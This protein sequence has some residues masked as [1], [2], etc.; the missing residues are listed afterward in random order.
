MRGF[1]MLDHPT[2]APSSPDVPSVSAVWIFASLVLLT[3][4]LDLLLQLVLR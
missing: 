3:V 1:E 2:R 4:L